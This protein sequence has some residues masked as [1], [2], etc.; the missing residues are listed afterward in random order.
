MK[1]DG[2]DYPIEGA[3]VAQ[4]SVSSGRRVNDH[5]L[6]IT[7]KVNGKTTDTERITLSPDRKAL[8][9][10]IRQAGHSAPDTLVFDR[11]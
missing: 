11:E 8:T 9:M 10:T 3:E 1:F 4:G 6:E 7:D 2:K 5:T